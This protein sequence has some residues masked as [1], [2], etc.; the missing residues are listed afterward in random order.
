MST[1]VRVTFSMRTQMIVPS[2]DKAL[3]CLLSW[4]AV[5]KAE[6]DD[7]DDPIAAQH[8]IGI[9]KHHVGDKWCFMASNV[10][11]AWKGD[12]DVL[13]YIKRSKLSDYT[14]AWMA[15]FLT[16]KPYFDGR[17]GATVAGSYIQPIRWAT[18]VT[19]F[20]VVED[21]KRFTE[22]LPWVTHIGKLH[23][24]DWG[25]VRSFELVEDPSALQ[26]WRYRNLPLD[27]P[28]CDGHKKG[29]GGLASPYWD[30]KKHCD[31]AVS[32]K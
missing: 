9:E 16:K 27:S 21:M 6:F 32:P 31:V 8:D 29:I 5:Q 24:K 2:V 14:D 22:L 26:Q 19:G 3:D 1:P 15:G 28:A 10:D 7:L 30:R 11:I 18:T 13:H 20:A 12:P 17:R 23:H 4:A 25:A